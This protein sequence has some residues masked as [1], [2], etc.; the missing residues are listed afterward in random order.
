[1]CPLLS[2][3]NRSGRELAPE[4]CAT[5]LPPELDPLHELVV[6][7]DGW[8]VERLPSDVERVGVEAIAGN[9]EPCQE[10]VHV[11]G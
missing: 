6:E 9:R 7:D 10:R 5:P 11:R 4:L 2:G 1:V 8:P 3:G